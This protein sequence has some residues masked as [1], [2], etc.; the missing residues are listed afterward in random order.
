MAHLDVI[1]QFS[2]ETGRSPALRLRL[3][4]GIASPGV[5]AAGAAAV[6]SGT[7]AVAGE[8]ALGL[9]GDTSVSDPSGRGALRRPAGAAQRRRSSARWPRRRRSDG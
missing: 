3:P 7:S 2:R 6:T 4:D 8:L 9:A 1:E 5:V